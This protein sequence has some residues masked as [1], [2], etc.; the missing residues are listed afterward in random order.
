MEM[1]FNILIF[2]KAARFDHKERTVKFRFW[3]PLFI[4]FI[5]IALPLSFIYC[6]CSDNNFLEVVSKEDIKLLVWW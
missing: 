6:A 3:H 5:L 2:L 4:L 1:I